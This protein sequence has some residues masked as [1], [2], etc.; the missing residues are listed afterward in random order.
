MTLERSGALPNRPPLVVHDLGEGIRHVE[1]NRMDTEE[2]WQQFDAHF[3]DFEGVTGL[4]LDVRWNGGGSSHVGWKVLARI[5]SEPT[6]SAAVQLPAYLPTMRAW[7]LPQRW[8]TLP[9][10]V[11]EPNQE[12][13]R[14]TGPVC[15][16]SGT[17]SFSA[18]EDFLVIAQESR[19]G[20][21]IGEPSG[22][23]TGQ[24]LVVELPGGGL[25]RVCTKRDTHPDG[26]LFVG[27]GVQPDIPC[28]PTVAGI[29]AGRDE[30]V[31]RAVQFIRTR[32]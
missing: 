22:G 14:F 30:I 31:E 12:L 5:L 18:A 7:G 20:P 3:P 17:F 32:S 19:R 29:A 28:A 15:F 13:P 27:P 11:I 21:L 4:I 1:V 25:F 26:A 8:L 24:P 10:K 23:S 9:G 6:R 16:L 2:T